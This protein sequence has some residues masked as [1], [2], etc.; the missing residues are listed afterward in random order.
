MVIGG[1]HCSDT[2]AT[3][4]NGSYVG[5]VRSSA[6]GQEPTLGVDCLRIP[7]SGLR[8]RRAEGPSW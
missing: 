1:G 7:Y 8:P 2:G 4:F 5:T 6:F 3:S